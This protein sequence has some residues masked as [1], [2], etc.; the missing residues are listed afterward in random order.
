MDEARR[1]LDT[2]MAKMPFDTI[3]GDANTFVMMANAYQAVGASGTAVEIARRAEPLVMSRLTEA[4]T[5][6]QLEL[7]AR[8]V[9]LIRLVYMDGGDFTLASEL[10]VR[11]AEFF[12][13]STFRQTPE[14]LQ[15][16]YEQSAAQNRRND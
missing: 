5:Q 14:E 1:L 7:A 4:R 10:G 3:P 13:D 8:Y 6:R 15:F 16:L 9:Q 2:L 11:L 12:G